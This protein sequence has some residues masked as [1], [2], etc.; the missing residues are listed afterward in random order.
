MYWLIAELF[1]CD[2]STGPALAAVAASPAAIAGCAALAYWFVPAVA[3]FSV[4]L[5][6]ATK[7]FGSVEYC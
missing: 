3:A 7:A 6:G 5:S 2:G 4:A 1:N